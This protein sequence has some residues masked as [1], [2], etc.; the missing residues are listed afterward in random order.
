VHEI[1]Q[2]ETEI[3]NKKL[4]YL[5][6]RPLLIES[7]KNWDC[8]INIRIASFININRHNRGGVPQR[9]LKKKLILTL[10]EW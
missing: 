5:K 10:S 9:K 1:V 2:L 4:S 3:K 6:K 8:Y 7:V